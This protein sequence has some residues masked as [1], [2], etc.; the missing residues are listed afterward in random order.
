MKYI[1]MKNKNGKTPKP[2]GLLT[3]SHFDL[4]KFNKKMRQLGVN[5]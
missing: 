5:K 1:E 4:K 2:L 3:G